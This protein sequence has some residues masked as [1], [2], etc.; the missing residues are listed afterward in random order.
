MLCSWPV[1][2]SWYWCFRVVRRHIAGLWCNCNYM[3]ASSSSLHF[4]VPCGSHL[5]LIWAAFLAATQVTSF[6]FISALRVNLYDCM[7]SCTLFP[8]KGCP[9]YA[10]FRPSKRMS[11]NPLPILLCQLKLQWLLTCQLPKIFISYLLRASYAKNYFSGTC[12]EIRGV[13]REDHWWSFPR[14]GVIWR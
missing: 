13:C 11:N 9:S 1:H 7:P 8:L 14:L 10:A 12:P 6:P 5:I 4:L 3:R 2:Y